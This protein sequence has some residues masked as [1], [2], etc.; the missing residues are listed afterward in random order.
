MGLLLERLQE[1]TFLS[2]NI[3]FKMLIIHR[4][5]TV[6]IE[7]SRILQIS[8]PNEYE[9]PQQHNLKK[10]IYIIRCKLCRSPL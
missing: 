6:V 3:G 10:A 8:H 1:N 7:V 9:P 4:Q 5:G 2:E